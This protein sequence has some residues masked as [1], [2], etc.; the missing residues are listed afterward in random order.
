MMVGIREENNHQQHMS[1]YCK[2]STVIFTSVSLPSPLTSLYM[3]SKTACVNQP[4]V[5]IS[6]SQE[7]SVGV[8]TD[9]LTGHV[10]TKI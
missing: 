3:R 8:K 6:S 4:Q 5:R 2:Y 9:P 1:T 7:S 10:S